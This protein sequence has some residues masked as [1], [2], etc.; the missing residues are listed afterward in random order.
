MKNPLIQLIANHFKLNCLYLNDQ[1]ND[2]ESDIIFNY[3]TQHRCCLFCKNRETCI[4]GSENEEGTCAAFEGHPEM[5]KDPIGF[6]IK[7]LKE[8]LPR[9]DEARDWIAIYEDHYG[10]N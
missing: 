1:I 2:E 5:I 4:Q 6:W 10:K 8:R 3:L 7:I 9:S